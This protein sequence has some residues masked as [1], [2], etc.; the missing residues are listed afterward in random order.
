[1]KGQL[2]PGLVVEFT[3]IQGD[4]SSDLVMNGSVLVVDKRLSS[5]HVTQPMES[6]II[7]PQ[8]LSEAT[9]FGQREH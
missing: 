4:F 8:L 3:H 2:P 1:M 9:G 5:S 6:A 7:S